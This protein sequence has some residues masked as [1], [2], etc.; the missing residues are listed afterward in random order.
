MFCPSPNKRGSVLAVKQRRVSL[1]S[2]ALDS[3]VLTK[4]EEITR[5]QL[6]MSFA[7]WNLILVKAMTL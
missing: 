3:F 7:R 6:A 1:E 2:S 5:K 4:R